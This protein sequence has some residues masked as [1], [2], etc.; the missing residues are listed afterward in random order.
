MTR[1]S[2]KDPLELVHVLGVDKDLKRH[3][4][5]VLCAAIE[6]HVVDR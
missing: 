1:V 4:L 5:L 6:H 2:A 3:F